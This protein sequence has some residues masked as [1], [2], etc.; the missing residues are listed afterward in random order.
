MRYFV[1]DAIG[2]LIEDEIDAVV[3]IPFLAIV[4]QFVVYFLLQ[5][6]PDVLL[7]LFSWF[8]VIIFGLLSCFCRR[9]LLLFLLFCLFLVEMQIYDRF[10]EVL[11]LV[12]VM[13]FALNYNWNLSLIPKLPQSIDASQSGSIIT[14]QNDHFPQILNIPLQHARRN[15][16]GYCE[17]VN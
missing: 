1:D 13:K 5:L 16:R 2:F 14:T 17:R 9:V 10:M 6:G 11:L 12:G 15:G 4:C 7:L 3:V 8:Q